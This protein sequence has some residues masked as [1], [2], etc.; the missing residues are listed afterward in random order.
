MNRL[1]RVLVDDIGHLHRNRPKIDALD[2]AADTSVGSQLCNLQS[3]SPFSAS[4]I[5]LNDCCM[6]C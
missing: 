5:D 2:I 4:K 6:V 3:T 1:L